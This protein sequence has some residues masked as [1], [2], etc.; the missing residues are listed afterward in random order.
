MLNMIR[1]VKKR[2]RFRFIVLFLLIGCGVLIKFFI[3]FISPEMCTLRG[4]VLS[5]DWM[6]LGA[7]DFCEASYLGMSRF[8]RGLG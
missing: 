3:V 1:D 2:H 5:Q 4:F 8:E 6:E 7:R